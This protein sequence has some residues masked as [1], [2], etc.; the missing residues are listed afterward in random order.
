MQYEQL[1][2]QLNTDDKRTRVALI[3]QLRAL[4][5]DSADAALAG[6][7]DP[8]PLVRA[9]CAAVLDHADHD[10]RIERALREAT[11]DPDARVRKS[12]LH[13][14]SCAHCKPDGCVV[15]DSVDYLVDAL[16]NDS[17]IRVRRNMAGIMMF[18]QAGRGPKVTSAFQQLVDHEDRVLRERASIYLA[19]V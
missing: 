3:E 12:A 8:R 11:R 1:V 14:L 5:P 7:R 13:S 19:S 9:A 2:A 6:L 4:L 15:D 10:D 17:S 16:L 18:G